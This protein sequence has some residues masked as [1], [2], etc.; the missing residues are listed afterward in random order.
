MFGGSV[1]SVK[2]D[3]RTCVST[4]T[5]AIVSESQIGSEVTKLLSLMLCNYKSIFKIKICTLFDTFS[6]F[7]KKLRALIQISA[8]LDLVTC[9]DLFSWTL[10]PSVSLY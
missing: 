2:K 5:T 10:C 3:R 6:N 4:Q 7:I 8:D 9:K 1:R